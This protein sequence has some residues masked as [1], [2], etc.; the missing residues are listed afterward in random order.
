[1]HSTLTKG[2]REFVPHSLWNNANHSL[3]SKGE[4][5]EKQS[6]LLKIRVAARNKPS[7]LWNIFLYVQL[8]FTLQRWIAFPCF[9]L[10]GAFLCRYVIFLLVWEGN[11]L[12]TLI[13]DEFHQNDNQ[14]WGERKGRKITNWDEPL[15]TGQMAVYAVRPIN[16]GITRGWKI[17]FNKLTI[18]NKKYF[19]K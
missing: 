6:K 16:L 13:G 4:I 7:I 18:Y 2:D 15:G 12:G 17:I 5:I 8:P 14:F 10:L 11:W 1:M 19:C 3:Y 9:E